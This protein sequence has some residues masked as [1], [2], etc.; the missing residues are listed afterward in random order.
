MVSICC[1]RPVVWFRGCPCQ[2]WPPIQRLRRVRRRYRLRNTN[3]RR[4]MKS[5]SMRL[6][7]VAFNFL[8]T[9]SASRPCWPRT[10]PATRF[11]AQRRW[12]FSCRHCRLALNVD[13]SRSK[14]G[15]SRAKT[16]LHSLVDR[17][18]NKKYGIYLHFLN[19]E[20]GGSPDFSKTK[21]HYELTASTVD[22]A[23]MQA[24]VM[25]AAFVFWRRRCH[26]SRPPD[27]RRRLAGNVR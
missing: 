27:C 6:R 15:K 14:K 1:V 10:R 18:D 3:S 24:G 19:G 8:G 9:K 26:T 5:C 20:T 22:N 13:G 25:T 11:A 21:Y 23:L 7:R 16:I 2:H 4:M 17:H 12:A